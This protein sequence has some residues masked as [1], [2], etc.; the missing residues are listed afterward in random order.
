ML[1]GLQEGKR[2]GKKVRR[3]MVPFIV[4]LEEPSRRRTIQLQCQ[5]VEC[6]IR[7]VEFERIVNR[8]GE[9]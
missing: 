5:T 1:L 3:E 4:L 2:K 7:V 8:G 9:E 6:S